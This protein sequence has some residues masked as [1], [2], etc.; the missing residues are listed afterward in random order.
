MGICGAL[1]HEQ[2][3]A[4]PIEVDLTL[5]VDLAAAGRSDELSDTVDY[6]DMAQ[7]VEAIVSEGRYVLLERLAEVIVG[8]A[9]AHERVSE[10]TVS[11]RKLRPPVPVHLD[12]TGVTITRTRSDSR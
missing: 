4:Q 8:A 11:V 9:L 3:Q 7:V 2:D 10:V 12:T 5:A 6:G 1:P